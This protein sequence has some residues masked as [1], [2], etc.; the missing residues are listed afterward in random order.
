MA[1]RQVEATQ[2]ELVLGAGLS[3]LDYAHVCEV[4]GGHLMASEC[5]NCNAPDTGNME[6]RPP[7]QCTLLADR[8]CPC[9]I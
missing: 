2:E 9:I 8:C 6:V 7:L 1:H 3:N 5:F 4:M